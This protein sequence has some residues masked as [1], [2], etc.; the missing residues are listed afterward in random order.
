M[1]FFFKRSDG[2]IARLSGVVSTLTTGDAKGGQT[3]SVILKESCQ[4]GQAVYED[5]SGKPYLCDYV[6]LT[7]GIYKVYTTPWN[8]KSNEVE[9]TITGSNTSELNSFT[10][11]DSGI[12]FKYPKDWKFDSV[13]N[14]LSRKCL[15]V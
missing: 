14:Y 10:H 9:F 5:Y 11:S 12:T 2:K 1:Y 15:I 4:Q 7:P 8:K 6:Q 3:A 13:K